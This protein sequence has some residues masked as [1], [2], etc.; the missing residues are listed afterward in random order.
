VGDPI[1]RA[2]LQLA[3]PIPVGRFEVEASLEVFNLFTHANFF[4][5]VPAE[6]SPSYAQPR[7]S[8]LVAYVPRTAALGLRVSF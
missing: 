1:H 2:D 8:F 7:Q 5:Y 4:Q 6:A 3:R